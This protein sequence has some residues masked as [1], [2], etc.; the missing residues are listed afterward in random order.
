MRAG[1]TRIGEGGPYFPE[2]R[3]SAISAARDPND[4]TCRARLEEL[5]RAYWKPVYWY[6][7]CTRGYSRE[8]AKDLTQEFF[9]HLLDSP[10]L[11]R[12]DR[13]RARF[14]TYLKACLGNFASKDFESKGRL[15]RG[16]GAKR[17]S[18][19]IEDEGEEGSP[20]GHRDAADPRAPN[21]EE[22]VDREWVKLLVDR[23]L[24]ATRETLAAQGKE[25]DLDVF[26]AYYLAGPDEPKPTYAAL[27]ERFA[28]PGSDLVNLLYRTRKLFRAAILEQIRDST[29]SEEEAR[30]EY[31]ELFG[32][33]P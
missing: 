17:F 21:P 4:P 26:R 13:S 28:I 1:D 6:L 10:M 33:D 5:C 23:A 25:R 32:E 15:K 12:A 24:V 11:E 14:R 30:L 7:C 2:T 18:L 8:E 31:R 19:E 22:I 29:A 3:W 20:S 27:S 16:G 9:M